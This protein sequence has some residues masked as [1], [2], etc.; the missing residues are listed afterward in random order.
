MHNDDQDPRT[1]CANCYGQGELLGL[2][3]TLAHLRCRNCGT[4]YNVP[5]EWL[6]AQPDDGDE[7]IL[8][9]VRAH[10]Q[11]RYNDAYGYSAV[12]ECFED[13]ELRE[14]LTAYGEAPFPSDEAAAI[15]EIESYVRLVSDQ[16]EDIR[17]A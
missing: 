4:V 1:A 2:L 9:A 11:A 8:A 13:E 17:G 6:P 16:Y 14:L 12:V 10:C 5:A 15:K 3:G 7:A